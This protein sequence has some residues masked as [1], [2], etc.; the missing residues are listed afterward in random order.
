MRDSDSQTVFSPRRAASVRGAQSHRAAPWTPLQRAALDVYLARSGYERVAGADEAGRGPLA[1]PVVAAAVILPP[2]LRL[3]GIDD[4]KRLS[5]AERAGCRLRILDVALAHAIV[6]VDVATIDRINILHASLEGL[7][8]AIRALDPAPQ[9]TLVDGNVLP[10]G[11]ESHFHEL[12]I[13]GD[14]RSQAIGAASVLAKEARDAI[15]RELDEQH[16]G[17]GFAQHKG[18]PT[19]AHFE[20]L[21][22]LGPCEAH[23]R[24]FAPVREALAGR[25]IAPPPPPPGSCDWVS[26]LNIS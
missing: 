2:G 19:P 12:L 23:R 26:D 15:L 10:P 3:T 18:Y 1:G 6:V 22:R 21:R 5:P 11:S 16:P 14:G 24:S 9:I 17:Y 8:R 7:S 25:C 20:A 13:K 4:S